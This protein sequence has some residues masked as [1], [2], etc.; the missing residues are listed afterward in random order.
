MTRTFEEL[1]TTKDRK[2]LAAMKVSWAIEDEPRAVPPPPMTSAERI[3]R[4]LLAHGW[5]YGAPYG[6]APVV[7]MYRDPHNKFRV[8]M[9]Q[10]AAWQALKA[11]M[12]AKANE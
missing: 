7:K 12:G 8:W 4:A 1:L 2:F 6:M 3:H 11:W 9:N 10:Q 5:E